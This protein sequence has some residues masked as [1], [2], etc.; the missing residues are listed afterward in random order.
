MTSKAMRNQTLLYKIFVIVILT[1]LAIFFI[2][3]LYWIITGSFK[4][5]ATIIAQTPQWFPLNP[6]LDNY[7]K[8]FKEPALR[9]LINTVGMAVGAMILT[10]I[11]AALAGYALAKKRFYGKAIL[12]TIIICAMALPKQ[13]IV[14]PLLQEMS[15]IPWIHI[16]FSDFTTEMATMH[17][18]MMAGIHPTVGWPFGVFLR[19]QFSETIPTEILEAARVDG[20]GELKT[21]FSIVFPMLKPGVGALAIFTFVNSWNDYFLQLI[22]LNSRDE[23]TI[24]LGIARLQGE[25]SSDFGLI[26]AGATLAAIPIV[27]IFIA[28]QKYFTQGIAMG[29][30]KG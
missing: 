29:A 21:F 16:D 1:L 4:D 5:N 23:W 9:W 19:K 11:T 2:F 15:Q 17:D 26:M 24:S 14:I 6:T 28:F 18:T 22:M 27:A 13:V 12:F 8:L 7:V 3:P 25:M 20:A 10:C 30:V